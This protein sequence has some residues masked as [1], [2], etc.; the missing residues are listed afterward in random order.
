MAL[1]CAE[2]FASV[3]A[4]AEQLAAI[5]KLR[6]G[7]TGGIEN[8]SLLSLFYYCTIAGGTRVLYVSQPRAGRQAPYS[9]RDGHI[10]HGH[11]QLHLQ[12]PLVAS[13]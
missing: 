12:S 4:A 13:I 9:V 3:C 1:L 11:Q 5:A 8:S 7:G 10:D 2:L 6:E